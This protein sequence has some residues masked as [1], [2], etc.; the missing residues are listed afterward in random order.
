MA[1]YSK[2]NILVMAIIAAIV[3]WLIGG[4]VFGQAVGMIC[5]IGRAHV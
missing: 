3:L 1:M 5:E 2:M 4:F